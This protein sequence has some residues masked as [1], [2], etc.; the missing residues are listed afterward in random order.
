MSNSAPVH[1]GSALGVH[2]GM[3]GTIRVITITRETVQ[4]A[5]DSATARHLYFAFSAFDRDPTTTVAILT[6]KGGTFCS[7]ADL[8]EVAEGKLMVPSEMERLGSMGP[9]R[10]RLTKPVIAAI[11]GSALAGGLELALWADLRVATT[12]AKFGLSGRQLGLPLVDQGTIRLPR[13]IGHSR[14]MDLLLTGRIIDAHEAHTIGLVNRLCLPGEALQRAIELANELSI[15]PQECL[16]NDRLTLIEQWDMD[17]S[18]AMKLE[19]SRARDTLSLGEAATG[20]RRVL[21]R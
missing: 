3:A 17:E 16:R 13:I 7:G 14:A 20:A 6:G 9:T 10:L 2:S 19:I 5:I 12:N 18:R 11:E 4:N 8:N 21:G 1:D 15:Y